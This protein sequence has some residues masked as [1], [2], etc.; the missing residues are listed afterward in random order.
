MHKCA[1]V[2]TCVHLLVVCCHDEEL[3]W[4]PIFIHTE[5]VIWQCRFASPK[6]ALSFYLLLLSVTVTVSQSFLL[7]E[8]LLWQQSCSSLESCFDFLSLTDGKKNGKHK[9][10]GDLSGSWEQNLICTVPDE[11]KALNMQHF[12]THTLLNFSNLRT[13]VSECSKYRFSGLNPG[14]RVWGIPDGKPYCAA[15]LLS[16][17]RNGVWFVLALFLKVLR[18]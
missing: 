7:Q 14:F 11:E 2:A 17:I 5:D 9:L 12:Q 15:L 3:L 10:S 4:L 13:L 18:V 6:S 1:C 16:P 8:A